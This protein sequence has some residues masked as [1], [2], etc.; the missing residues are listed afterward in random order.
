LKKKGILLGIGK[1][2][3]NVH[4]ITYREGP[5]LERS[6]AIALLLLITS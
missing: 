1:G 2:K 3:G 6:T 4:L 5:E